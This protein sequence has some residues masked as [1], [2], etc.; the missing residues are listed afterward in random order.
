MP[1]RRSTALAVL[2]LAWVVAGVPV[3]AQA[4]QL[5]LSWSDNSSDE[6]GFV[7]ER[8]AAAGGFAQ[9]GAVGANVVTFLDAGVVSGEQYCYRVRAINAAGPSGYTNEVCGTATGVSTSPISVTLNQATFSSTDTLVATVI[10]VGGVIATP[11]DAYVVIEVGGGA[12]LSLQLDGRLVPGLVP[13]ASNFI[14]PS[15]SAPFAFPLAGAPPGEYRWLAAV[16]TPGTLTL[17]SP[18]ASTPFTIV[19]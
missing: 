7:I 9:I 19:P 14:V 4:A 12:F 16:T 2:L 17:I 10:A 15:V 1:S 6:D 11:V 3:S 5:I 8:R 13:I 18:L